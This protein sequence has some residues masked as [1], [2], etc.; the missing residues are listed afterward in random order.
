[1]LGGSREVRE[2]FEKE[3]VSEF[4]VSKKKPLNILTYLGAVGDI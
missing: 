4:S 2:G 1:M 3:N